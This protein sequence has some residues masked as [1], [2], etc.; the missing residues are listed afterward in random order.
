VAR[1]IRD[2]TNEDEVNIIIGFNYGSLYPYYSERRALM[3]PDLPGVPE[4]AR[5]EALRKAFLSLREKKL[6][7]MFVK[8]SPRFRAEGE[9][10]LDFMAKNGMHVK[11]V[12][13][14]NSP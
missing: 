2:H 1:E 11:Y 7:I 13:V 3:V 9:H 12:L 5:Q 14:V 10:W 4:A 6:G 8:N